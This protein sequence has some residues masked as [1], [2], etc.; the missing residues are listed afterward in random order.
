MLG[1]VQVV[2]RANRARRIALVAVIAAVG[3]C[4]SGCA[5]LAAQATLQSAH[6]QSV[7]TGTQLAASGKPVT[8]D[9]WRSTYKNA[10]KYADWNSAKPVTCSAAHQLYTYGVPD[11]RGTFSGSQYNSSGRLK[12]A[13]SNAEDKACVNSQI[14]SELLNND[15]E[16]RVDFVLFVP[17]RAE[18]SR[19]A[20]WV[21]CDIGLIALGSKYHDP[22][23]E[24]LPPLDTVRT[25]IRF[26]ALSL[27]YCANDPQGP[28]AGPYSADAVY[29]DCNGKPE[30]TQA[31]GIPVL[32]YLTNDYPSQVLMTQV[33]QDRCV[34]LWANATHVTY[35]HYP[36]EAEWADGE[37]VIECWVG[38]K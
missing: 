15:F 27:D 30:W 24:N 9:C 36:T 28:N 7:N 22:A 23:L 14:E 38:R 6:A 34:A 35:A 20:R 4:L 25:S 10:N 31:D 29:A 8:G 33:Y 17:S 37:Q 11:I 26:K 16:G 21:R 2:R 5:T 19:G 13:I 18:W 1:R 32:P 3:F 12:D